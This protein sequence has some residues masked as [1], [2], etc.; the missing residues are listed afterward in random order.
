MGLGF[1]SSLNDR[2]RID[3]KARYYIF[4]YINDKDREILTGD[5]RAR[6]I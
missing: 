4:N 6:G 1:R 2:R 5:I 3:I